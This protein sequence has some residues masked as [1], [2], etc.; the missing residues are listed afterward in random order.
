MKEAHPGQYGRRSADQH[1]NG[2]RRQF[3]SEASKKDI[4]SENK[5]GDDNPELLPE[6]L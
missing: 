5:K 1:R 4:D 3:I 6:F 2:S